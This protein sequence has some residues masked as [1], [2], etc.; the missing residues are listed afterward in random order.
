MTSLRKLDVSFAHEQENCQ[1]Y[2]QADNTFFSQL[3]LRLSVKPTKS[4]KGGNWTRGCFGYSKDTLH[5]RF[6]LQSLAWFSDWS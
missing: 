4:D 2:S 1:R 5:I 3:A 6:Y